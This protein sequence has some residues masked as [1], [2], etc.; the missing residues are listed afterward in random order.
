M[1][2]TNGAVTTASRSTISCARAPTSMGTT[3][4]SR[5]MVK[6]D[7]IADDGE[8]VGLVRTTSPP[9]SPFSL[10]PR[11]GVPPQN[12]AIETMS[13]RTTRRGVPGSEAVAKVAVVDSDSCDT[14][15]A[16]APARANETTS[17]GI[18]RF[19]I[20]PP[21]GSR[22]RAESRGPSEGLALVDAVE[23]TR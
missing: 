19:T 10:A 23:G 4:G 18:R 17:A 3:I 21:V 12:Q 8:S 9:Y 13:S 15:N 7:T 14:A 6:I 22:V 20:H 5:S 16:S 1:A 2:L 11:A